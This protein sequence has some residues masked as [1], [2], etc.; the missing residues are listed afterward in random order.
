MPVSEGR[1][2]RDS[3]ISPKGRHLSFYEPIAGYEFRYLGQLGGFRLITVSTSTAIVAPGKVHDMGLIMESL[4][5]DHFVAISVAIF[6]D[7]LF[8]SSA[9]EPPHIAHHMIHNAAAA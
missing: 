6:F 4:S 3:L 8:S 2:P 9:S 7:S 1:Y 5:T